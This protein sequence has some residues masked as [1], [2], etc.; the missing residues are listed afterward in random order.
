MFTLQKLAVL[1][2]VIGAA[3]YGFR[4]VERLQEMRRTSA[5]RAGGEAAARVSRQDLRAC[6]A[7][8]T[9]VAEGAACACGGSD[10]PQG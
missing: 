7:C 4:L 8:G 6:S 3:W 1:I 10:R 2:A 5:R 9:Y